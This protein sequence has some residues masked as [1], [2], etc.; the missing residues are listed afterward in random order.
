MF[1]I[2]FY[3]ALRE[4]RRQHLTK[5]NIIISHKRRYP[6]SS[7]GNASNFSIIT[8]NGYQSGDYPPMQLPMVLF[9]ARACTMPIIMSIDMETRIQGACRRSRRWKQ[10]SD[11]AVTLGVQTGLTTPPKSHYSAAASRCQVQFVLLAK[12]R[13]TTRASCWLWQMSSGRVWTKKG[14]NRA[15]RWR[16]Q[17]RRWR[18]RRRVVSSED[19]GRHKSNYIKLMRV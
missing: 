19:F 6:F 18:R 14:K 8:Y 9:R 13:R 17:R 7:F 15:R 12:A 16:R 5:M 2:N 1:L 11:S 10:K 3:F 4:K